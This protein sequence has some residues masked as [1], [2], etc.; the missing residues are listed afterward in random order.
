LEIASEM[1]QLILETREIRQN[2]ERLERLAEQ[3]LALTGT[4]FREQQIRASCN[5]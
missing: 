3:F 2:P 5:V 4:G 1:A